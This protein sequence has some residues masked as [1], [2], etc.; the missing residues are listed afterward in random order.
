MS[1]WQT[2][3]DKAARVV[4]DG[5]VILYPA[6]TI[7][8]LGCDAR[9]EEAVKR[10]LAIKGRTPEKGLIAIVESEGRLERHVSEVPRVVWDLMDVSDRPL[11]II[12]PK[13][14]NLANFVCA[15]DGSAALRITQDPLCNRII[16]K[17]NCP[18]VSTS[19]NESGRKPAGKLE[20][21]PSSLLSQVDYVVDLPFV[22]RSSAR[23][24]SIIRVD[25]DGTVSIIRK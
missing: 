13:G 1:D 9:N 20:E 10:I 8:G 7:W 11:T 17:A 2:E 16:H 18:L 15:P 24:S 19:A 5:G 25:L 12:Y 22:D 23:P 3:A 21:M 6:D 4:K 14:V